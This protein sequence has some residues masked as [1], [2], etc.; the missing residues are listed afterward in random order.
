MDKLKTRLAAFL[1]SL[2]TKLTPDWKH[3]LATEI[4]NNYPD[5]LHRRWAFELTDEEYMWLTLDRESKQRIRR[6]I[7]EWGLRVDRQIL[8]G[9]G[10]NRANAIFPGDPNPYIDPTTGL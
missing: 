2:V 8:F 1:L 7:R 10:A 6:L 3:K 9:S 5:T 4:Y